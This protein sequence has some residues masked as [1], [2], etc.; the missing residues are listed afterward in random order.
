MT[1]F[2]RSGRESVYEGKVLRVYR[3]CV[4]VRRRAGT[5]VQTLTLEHVEHPG[6]ACVVPFLDRERILLLRQFR[7]SAGGEI[8]E[9]PAGKLDGDEPMEQCAR[10]ELLEETGYHPGK[11]ELLGTLIMTPGFSDE[12]C[13]IFAATEL[14][15]RQANAADDE[16]LEVIEMPFAEAVA[17]VEEGLIQDSKT[18]A[19]LLLAA[20]RR[21]A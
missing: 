1:E 17:M 20:R 12:R 10:R 5:V 9:I 3:D 2:H 11:L 8:W 4:E 15:K 18:V 13:A 21:N 6:A 7:Y 19:G 14:E 16:F